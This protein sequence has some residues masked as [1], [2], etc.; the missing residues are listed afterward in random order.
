M[1]RF[2]STWKA[3]PLAVAVVVGCT[4]TQPCLVLGQDRPS[5]PYE[6]TVETD[7]PYAD[8]FTLDVYVPDEPGPFPTAVTFHGASGGKSA[9]QDLASRLAAQGWV[10]F[11]ADW[12]I[13]T[14]PLDAAA[15]EQSFEAAGCALRFA[16]GSRRE[17]RGDNRALSVV[18]LSAGGLAGALVSLDTSEF[19]TA[20][21]AAEEQ[22]HV[23]LFI[24]LEGAYLNA[25]EGS[26]GLAAAIRERPHLAKRLDPRSYVG[27]AGS[28]R[29]VLFLGDQFRPAVAGT[30]A[31]L[32]SLQAVGV[33]AEIRR[34]VG[35]HRAS[36][37]TQGVLELLAEVRE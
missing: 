37:F 18:G 36:T 15:L 13:S 35:P 14:R 22:P 30:E 7:I 1:I 33:P 5:A 28:I 2:I 3:R 32:V 20:C 16:A 11:N 24:G 6:V 8:G 4:L 9:M 19:G 12:L 23:D 25:A 17:Y 10:V 34:A 21:A 26:D 27:Q 29:V 31:F